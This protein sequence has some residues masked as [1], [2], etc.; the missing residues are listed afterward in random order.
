[1]FESSIPTT[2]A[3]RRRPSISNPRKNTMAP[4]SYG[5]PSTPAFYILFCVATVL[6]LKEVN[7]IVWEPYMVS[8]HMNSSVRVRDGTLLRLPQ[9]RTVPRRTESGVLQRRMD[10]VGSK[11]HDPAG[12][13]SF[14]HTQYFLWTS[15][16]WPRYIEASI[17]RYI[18]MFKCRLPLLRLI[19]A[20]HLMALPIIISIL[21]AYHKRLPTPSDLTEPSLYSITIAMLP[22]LW[23]FGHL[24][25]TDVPSLFFVLASF[26]AQTRDAPWTAAFVRVLQTSSLATFYN[27]FIARSYK[28]ALS[29]DKHY[30]DHLHI[31]L[32]SNIVPAVATDPQIA[33]VG[34]RKSLVETV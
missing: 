32:P 6:V 34:R 28:P 5:V 25:Y 15:H 22:P 8:K 7:S 21:E 1:M 31:R 24:F 17:L 13:V 20:L 30:M 29:S 9:G 3:G 19:P 27:L 2:T 10:N 33:A 12:S 18:F 23:F 11:N 4:S 14:Y 16:A 26:A